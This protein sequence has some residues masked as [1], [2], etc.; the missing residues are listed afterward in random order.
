MIRA[1]YFH[2]VEGRMRI[3]IA[4]AKGSQ[5]KA[6]E[7]TQRLGCGYGIIDVNANPVTGN[8]LINYDSRLVSQQ[9]VLER[10]RAMGYLA[11]RELLALNPVAKASATPGWGMELVRFG[12]ETLLT[13]LIL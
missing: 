12:L 8:V 11:G 6:G 9:A 5:A 10:L 7:I 13:A 3:H 2:A 1:V 4:E